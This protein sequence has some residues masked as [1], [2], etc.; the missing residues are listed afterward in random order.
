M[1]QADEKLET[2]AAENRQLRDKVQTR[3]FEILA[4]GRQLVAMLKAK[5]AAEQASRTPA[6]IPVQVNGR[7]VALRYVDTG[8]PV[9]AANVEAALDAVVRGAYTDEDEER[10]RG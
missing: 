6:G 10:A 8:E 9:P 4:L 3:D 7:Q 1:S 5:D 2:M